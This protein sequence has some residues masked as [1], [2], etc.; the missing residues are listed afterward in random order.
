MRRLPPTNTLLGPI[1]LGC[2]Q[3]A[4]AASDAGISPATLLPVLLA[5]LLIGWMLGR[6]SARR[7]NAILPAAM[8]SDQRLMWALWGS[9]DSFWIWE[10][11]DDLLSWASA[12]PVLGFSNSESI[13][14]HDWRQHFVHRDDRLRVDAAIDAHLQGS[15]EQYEVEYRLRDATGQWHWVR[16]R[17]RVVA[18][19]EAGKPTL[20]AGTFRVIERERAQDAERRISAE[21]IRHM[22]EGVSIVDLE[23]HFVSA[24]PAFLRLTGYTAEELAG[25]SAQILNSDRQVAGYYDEVR[26]ELQRRGHWSG[27]MWQRRRSGDDFLAWLQIAEVLSPE[28]ARSNFVAVMADITDR[29][30]AEQRLRYL[31]HF[32]QLTSLPNRAFLRQRLRQRIDTGGSRRFALMFM[33]L[34]RFKH[35]NDSLGHAAGDE[36][37]R[38]AAKRLAHVVGDAENV[39]RF[40]GDEFTVIATGDTSNEGVERLAGEILDAFA[41]PLLVAGQELAIS[42]SIG[43]AYYPDHGRN[44]DELLRH[45]DAAMYDAKA[46]GRNTYRVY[47]ARMAEDATERTRLEAALRKA[48]DRDEIRLVYQPKL[49]L[50]SGRITGVEALLRWRSADLG[51]VPPSRFIPLAEETGLILP[52]GEWA[53]RQALSQ[54]RA[55]ADAGMPQLRIAVNVSAVQLTRGGF[56]ELV[57]MVLDGHGLA[58]GWLEIELTES[59]LMADP[60]RTGATVAEL[61][62]IGVRVAIDDFGTGYSSLSYLRGLAIDTVKIDKSFV[63]GIEHNVDDEVLT[64]TIVL[65]AHSLGLSVVAEGVET[66]RQLTFLRG[67]NCDEIQGYWLARPLDAAACRQFVSGYKMPKGLVLPGA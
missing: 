15:Q 25:Q 14:G 20:V 11:G 36:L 29:K 48:L 22:L 47:S 62:E 28:G 39:A 64:S 46:R 41:G 13:K 45:A 65:M 2:P 63:D 12:D 37:L 51:H 35:V 21:V 58:P 60:K 40:G 56:S 1:L 49:S 43:I 27:E 3:L 61:R 31:A 33:D 18:R 19:N 10:V 54:A 6:R 16:A 50:R 5:V 59:A 24:N 67:E 42:P 8:A 30:R 55:W 44:M 23:F 17:G 57:K 52:L 9:G 66:E 4:R 32:D 7:G 38:Q 26:Q 34:D 53:L